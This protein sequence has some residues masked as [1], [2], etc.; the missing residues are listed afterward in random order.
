MLTKLRN[1]GA[2]ILGKANL[3]QRANYR[4]SPT[5]SSHGW[6]ATGGQT[7][8]VYYPGQNPGG[9]SAGSAV[10][11]ALGLA[12]G[13]LGTDVS[14]NVR[15]VLD[16]EVLI[17][18]IADSGKHWQSSTAQRLGWLEAYRGTDI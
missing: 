15:A 7:C 6:S 13:A 16:F 10:A 14:W 4:S 18:V 1:A 8:G 2:I 12:A 17:L 9:S 5:S 11:V 3:T